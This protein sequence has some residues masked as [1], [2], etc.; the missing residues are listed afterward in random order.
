[1]LV[2]RTQGRMRALWIRIFAIVSA[3]VVGA[4]I[5]ALVTLASL[6]DESAELTRAQDEIASLNDAVSKAEDRMWKLYREREALAQQLA[7]QADGETSAAATSPEVFGA[8]VHL[9]DED[10]APGDYD[11]VVVEEFGYW[12]R[13]KSTDGTVN[14]IIENG[15]VYGPFTLTVLPSD[16]AVELRGIELSPR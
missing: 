2:D 12:A 7:E 14:S 3:L 13:L 10:M 9:V 16:R 15:L 4:V 8:G 6:P 1:M 5:G 11:G